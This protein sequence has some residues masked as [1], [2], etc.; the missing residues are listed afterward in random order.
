MIELPVFEK[1]TTITDS[2]K[3]ISMAEIEWN[4]AN[5]GEWGR[6]C[7][8]EGNDYID[9]DGVRYF[10]REKYYKVID[11]DTLNMLT[12]GKDYKIKDG[13]VILRDGSN[14]ALPRC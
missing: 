11:I 6:R 2:G 3:C 8:I 4:A 7:R 9:G 1:E 10:I 12:Y 14:W 13:I 5:R